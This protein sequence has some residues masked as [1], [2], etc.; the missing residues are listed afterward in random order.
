VFLKVEPVLT[1]EVRTEGLPI[2]PTGARQYALSFGE[3]N[4]EALEVHVSFK[5]GNKI[6]ALVCSPD[7]GENAEI[8]GEALE[9]L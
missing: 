1:S 5:E 3:G 4:E 6:F 9:G 2:R 7:F 8:G